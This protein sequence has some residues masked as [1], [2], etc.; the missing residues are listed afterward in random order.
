MEDLDEIVTTLRGLSAKAQ[1]VFLKKYTT[2][3]GPALCRTMLRYAC[4]RLDEINS[5][6]PENS[7]YHKRY[8]E[9]RERRKQRE[10]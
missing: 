7:E 8:V 2:Q 10:Q 6:F 4:H 5:Q 9:H 1:A 3:I